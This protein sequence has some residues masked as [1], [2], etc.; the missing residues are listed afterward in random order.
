MKQAAIPAF[1]KD[2]VTSP[3]PSRLSVYNDDVKAE[4]YREAPLAFAGKQ[5]KGIHELLGDC[6]SYSEHVRKAMKGTSA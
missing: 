3:H 6:S 4:P 5:R 2:W 1:Q